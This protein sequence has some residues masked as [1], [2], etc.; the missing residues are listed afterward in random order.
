MSVIEHVDHYIKTENHKPNDAIK[1][2]AKDRNMQKRE[3][4]QA[5]HIEEV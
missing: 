2:V 5:Y 4:Y 1:R 3:V